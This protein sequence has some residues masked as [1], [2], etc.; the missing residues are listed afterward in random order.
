MSS[1]WLTLTW[2]EEAPMKAGDA[3]IPGGGGG[4]DGNGE[5][6]AGVPWPELMIVQS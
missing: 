1:S 4:V 6:V 2:G 3:I 5:N